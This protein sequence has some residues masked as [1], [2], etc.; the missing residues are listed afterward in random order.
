MR[1]AELQ[2]NVVLP[3]YATGLPRDSVAYVSQ[4]VT[5]DQSQLLERTGLIPQNLLLAILGG[6]Q[7]VLSPS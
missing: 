3:S 2:G 7:V 1:L 6:I 4:V 5:V